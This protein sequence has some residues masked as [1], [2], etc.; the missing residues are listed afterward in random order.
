VVACFAGIPV[1]MWQLIGPIHGS[2]PD[3]IDAISAEN[4][5]ELLERL[6]I[7]PGQLSLYVAYA[8]KDQFNIDAQVESFLEVA[9]QRGIQVDVGYEPNGKHSLRTGL[10][11]FP[12]ITAWLNDRLR[13]FAVKSP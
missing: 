4:P 5:I 3:A 13:P 6:D 12:G 11:L 10:K 7:K 9:R 2:G 1:C 8:G